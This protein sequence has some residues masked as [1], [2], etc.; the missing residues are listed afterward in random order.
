VVLTGDEL[1]PVSKKS[2]KKKELTDYGLS[3][4][5]DKD[6]KE[7]KTSGAVLIGKY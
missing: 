2:W 7:I 4:Q 3:L 1:T 5:K 6:K